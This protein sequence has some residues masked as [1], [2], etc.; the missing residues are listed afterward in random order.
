[1]SSDYKDIDL[2]IENSIVSRVEFH[3]K[4]RPDDELIA[5]FL[6]DLEEGIRRMRWDDEQTAMQLVAAPVRKATTRSEH[7]RIGE[8]ILCLAIAEHV[9][10]ENISVPGKMPVYRKRR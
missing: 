1:M 10:I 6:A 8:L 5:V 9:D 7:C 3:S 2:Q 4:R